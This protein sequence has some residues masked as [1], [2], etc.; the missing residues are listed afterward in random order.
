[1]DAHEACSGC[2]WMRGLRPEILRRSASCGRQL[3]CEMA[4]LLCAE[5]Q[6]CGE[7]QVVEW[8]SWLPRSDTRDLRSFRLFSGSMHGC[9]RWCCRGGA[10]GWGPKDSSWG[11]QGSPGWSECAP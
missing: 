6:Q 10:K 5:K 3:M 4:T 7:M 2:P 8:W 11:W 9:R 1:M